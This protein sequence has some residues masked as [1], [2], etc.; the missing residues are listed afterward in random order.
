M[1]RALHFTACMVVALSA[2][3]CVSPGTDAGTTCA[4]VTLSTDGWQRFDE[5]GFTLRLPPDFTEVEAR[6]IDSQVGT[7]RS[8]DGGTEI[9]YD[10]GFYSSDLAADTTRSVESERCTAVIGGKPATIVVATMRNDADVREGR[11]HMVAGAWRNVVSGGQ[12]AIHLTV[13]AA[14]S[15][16]TRIP[17]LRAVLQSVQF[18]DVD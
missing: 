8:G 3:A 14:T 12:Q 1:T 2:A 13:W 10:F 16:S 6:G 18:A 5:D 4:P 11:R 15:D 9:T 7:F 17:E